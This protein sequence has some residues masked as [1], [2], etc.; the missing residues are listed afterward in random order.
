MVSEIRIL[1]VDDHE[2]VRDALMLFLEGQPDFQLVGQASTGE[3][4]IELLQELNPHVILIDIVM[5]G[6]GGFVAIQEI[7]DRFPL[8]LLIALTSHEIEISREKVMQAGAVDYLIKDISGD[9]MAE[10]IRTAYKHWQGDN[11]QN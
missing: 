10:A 7:H 6:I 3:E 11:N 8:I 2:F 1:I 4:A 5:P 9:T